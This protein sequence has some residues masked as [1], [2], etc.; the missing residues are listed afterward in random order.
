MAAGPSVLPGEQNLFGICSRSI[1]FLQPGARFRLS[2]VGAREN[3][4]GQGA[5]ADE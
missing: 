2:C 5:V 4:L 3:D 1:H